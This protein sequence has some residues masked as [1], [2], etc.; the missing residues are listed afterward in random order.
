M[1]TLAQATGPRRLDPT[2][3]RLLKAAGAGAVA[4]QLAGRF[5]RRAHA[6]P[7]SKFIF[8]WHANGAPVASP[9]GN[10]SFMSKVPG[11]KARTLSFPMHADH[12]LGMPFSLDGKTTG[13]PAATSP[14]T[15]S[16]IDQQVAAK[17]ASPAIVL[18]GKAK[19]QNYRGWVSARS[20]ANVLPI[21]SPRL[22]F[23][24]I[25]G[26]DPGGG[27]PAPT[28]PGGAPPPGPQPKPGV[29]P[30]PAE[31]EAAIFKTALDDATRVHR[32]LPAG[33]ERQK[34]D[35]HIEALRTLASKLDLQL[36]P[37]QALT[38]KDCKDKAGLAAGFQEPA[39]GW[40][41]TSKVKKLMDLIAVSF[42]CGRR[43]ATLMLTPGGHDSMNF[44]FIGIPQSDPH[45]TIAHIQPGGTAMQKIKE[46]D[47]SMLAYLVQTLKETP[48]PAGGSVLDNTLILVAT[49]TAFG[50][51]SANGVPVGVAGGLAGRVALDGDYAG[52]LKA[53]LDTV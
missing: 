4:A 37:G 47:M 14:I 1:S 41:P 27:G 23:E 46:W 2:R 25:F 6:A 52:I 49:E 15:G 8:F 31:V 11:I 39:G 7:A 26:V 53:C 44:G 48:D 19:H 51:H 3:R 21:E 16:S 40:D 22:A 36:G 45:N 12:K 28:P 38:V 24:Q 42:A 34:M 9:P 18:T 13:G 10:T 43:V 35:F 20:G 29:R 30:L 32:R 33:P 5:A 50:N 17:L